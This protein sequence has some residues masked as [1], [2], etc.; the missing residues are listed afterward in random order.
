MF[1]W[2]KPSPHAFARHVLKGLREFDAEERFEYRCDEFSIVSKRYGSMALTNL[3][4][5]YA[6]GG[7]TRRNKIVEQIVLTAK[8]LEAGIPTL[9]EMAKDNILPTLRSRTQYHELILAAQIDESKFQPAIRQRIDEAIVVD[10]AFDS[11]AS[12]AGVSGENLREWG[13][14]FEEALSV[15]KDNLRKI[16]DRPME[17]VH[18]GVYA[19][20]GEDAYESSRLLLPDIFHRLELDGDPVALIPL[21]DVLLVTGHRDEKGLKII[22]EI[23]ENF[24]K[25][26]RWVSFSPLRH[27]GENWQQFDPLQQFPNLKVYS[28]LKMHE[29]VADYARQKKLLEDLQRHNGNDL[30]VATFN[31]LED[32][33]DGSMWSYCVWTEGVKSLLPHTEMV[34]FT[35]PGSEKPGDCICEAPWNIVESELGH[36]I[37]K[38]PL[39]P[40]RYQVRDFPTPEELEKLAKVVDAS[41]LN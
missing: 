26:P 39:W 23:A 1:P 5:D 20:R 10:I 36:Y 4:D 37:K 32:K 30:F 34:M 2:S 12:I 25:K 16:S 31:G 18:D 6:D 15:A 35:K 8:E 27:D 28:R 40:P 7:R 21:R 22:A 24:L 29:E 13:V 33:Q 14:G 38:I 11:P 19:A 17:K 3:Y 41:A 9:W